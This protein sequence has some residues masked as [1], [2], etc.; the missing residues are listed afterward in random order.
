MLGASPTI[1]TTA[2]PWI[3]LPFWGCRH[4]EAG[5]SVYFHD[6][7]ARAINDF[8]SGIAG[9]DDVYSQAVGDFARHL[10]SAAAAGRKFFLDKTPRYFLMLP[11]LRAALPEA[12]FVI[13][14][15]HPLA[16]LAS[17]GE[18]FYRGRFMWSDYWLDWLTGHRLLA[19]AVRSSIPEMHVV[20][21]EQLVSDPE[22]VLPTICHHIGIEYSTDML[23]QYRQVELKGRMGDPVG[24]RRYESV[25]IDSLQ[26]WRSFF[27]S[28]FR[29]K[30]AQMMLRLL[31]A[32][33]LETL[34]Y[35]VSSLF[36]ELNECPSSL[37]W[38]WAGRR[39]RCF[40]ELAKSFD[41]RY[42][43]ARWRAWRAGQKFAYGYRSRGL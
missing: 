23:S 10:Y 30:H 25:S 37:G 2:E 21:Y 17:I 15:R 3:M 6:T 31:D 24:V 14:L 34:G 7:A 38:D 33:D 42:L 8:I 41:Y 36:A 28:D 20:H 16:V 43:Q 39:D 11:E 5:R 4:P 1:A 13:L 12:R 27:A 18:T 40:D 19:E 26:K 22:S 29:R 9:G 32:S 35:P